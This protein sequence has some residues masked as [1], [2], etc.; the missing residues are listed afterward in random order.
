[1]KR[2]IWVVAVLV[3][4][5]VSACIK[6]YAQSDAATIKGMEEQWA[7][8][9]SKNDDAGVASLVAENATAIGSDGTM[10]NKK[11]MLAVMKDRKYE[12]AT[13]E[14]IQVQ[15]YGNAAVATGVWRAKGTEKGKP[16]SETE[17]FTDTYVK[18]DGQWK[19]VATQSSAMK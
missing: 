18:M 16:F 6:V 9:A 7:A 12:S 10:R 1:M 2:S 4:L 19:C 3:L 15:V 8:A 11:E 13:E 5:G 17:R 14:D